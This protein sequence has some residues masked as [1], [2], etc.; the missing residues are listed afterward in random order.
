MKTNLCFRLLSLL[1]T[2]LLVPFSPLNAQN[3]GPANSIYGMNGTDQRTL[4]SIDTLNGTA[5]NI[6][7]VFGGGNAASDPTKQTS[8]IAVDP[9]TGIIWFTSRT[10]GNIYSYTPG[11]AN[12]YGTTTAV[13]GVSGNINKAAYNPADSNI[14]FHISNTLY[15]FKTSTPTVAPVPIGNLGLSGA[16]TTDANFSGGD[17]AFDSL[18]N[19]T[20]VFSDLNA[21]AVFPANYD[22]NGNYL[23]LNLSQGVILANFP[24]APS[25]VAFLPSGD[26]LVGSNSLGVVRVN[27]TTG[28]QTTLSAFGTSDYASCVAPKPHLVVTQTATG[29]CTAANQ[30]TLTFTITVRNNGRFAAIN[31]H[32]FDQLPA[33][34]TITGAT[35]NGTA[36]PGA[37]NAMFQTGSG[38]LIS[39]TG[40]AAFQNGVLERADSAKIVI[41]AT[42]VPGMYSNQAGISYTGVETLNLPN[43]RVPSDDPG[44]ATANDP[45]TITAGCSSLAGTVF[46]DANGMTDN[47]V[48]GTGTGTPGGTA[49]YIN[50]VNAGGIVIASVP[51]NANGT[52]TISNI[53]NGSYTAQLSTLRGTA[54]QTAPAQQ[55][56]AGWVNTGESFGGVN[57]ATVGGGLPLTVNGNSTNA[58]LGI[59]RLPESYAVTRAITGA[60]VLTNLSTQPLQG[61]DPEDLPAQGSWS[62]R[63]FIID[64][65]PTNGYILKYNGAAVVA[66]NPI[67]NYNPALLTIEPGATSGGTATTTFKYSTVDAAGKKDPTPAAY[68]INW[69]IALPVQL[70]SFSGRATKDCSVVLSWSTGKEERLEHF[71]L[72]RSKDG[73]H[74]ENIAIQSPKGSNSSYQYTD[75]QNGAAVYY[76]RL[77]IKDL[78]QG[79]AYSDVVPVGTTCNTTI[80]VYPNPASD[81]VVI[82]GLSDN[83]E[84]KVTDILG[85]IVLKAELHTGQTAL[86]ISTL[87]AGTYYFVFT[88]GGQTQ[89]LKILKK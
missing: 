5:T 46:N 9:V 63:T 11:A 59:E 62:G 61:S 82:N 89:T 31:S 33:G 66:G 21:L 76:Y 39:S 53:P 12:P 24:S 49:V 14:Y 8:A 80:A 20:G 6:G 4:V 54:G 48:N 87:A 45:T 35:L 88:T 26:Y 74:F 17:I 57:D 52:Y 79:E 40:A 51:V 36:I 86:D 32:I 29:S 85:A 16:S 83:A 22:A 25:S 27:T 10:P 69:S 42:G 56:P 13:F 58:N 55:L 64:T 3:C 81:K 30:V 70:R 15:R 60:P 65:L 44:T 68:R 41:T 72:Q 28:A 73:V 71:A 47:V 50:L 77:Y 7:D 67:A 38:P 37:N 78:D 75:A 84:L 18:G 34:L 23:G 43:D 1:A 2:T 19:L